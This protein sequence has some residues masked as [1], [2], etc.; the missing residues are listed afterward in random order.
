MYDLKLIGQRIKEVRKEKDMTLDDVAKTVGV[1][2]STIQRYEAGLITT[3]KLPVLISIA[4]ALGVNPNWIKGTS[5]EK[6]AV[7]KPDED[8]VPI[9]VLGEVSAGP[10]K[11]AAD[12]ITGYIMEDMSQMTS[13]CDYVYLKV[14][15]DSMYPEFKDGDLVFVKCEPEVNSGEYAV[16]M[17]DNEMG[18]VKRLVY[19][20]DYIELQSVNPMYPPRRFNGADME[21]I[22]VFG[23]VKGMKR[24]F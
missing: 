18:V 1:A 6:N 2:K 15:G 16:V 22:R 8:R 17:V 12:N 23:K 4:G 9:P 7:R 19:G 21:K 13:D 14:A 5:S 20:N 10:G 11:Y 3:P 24:T